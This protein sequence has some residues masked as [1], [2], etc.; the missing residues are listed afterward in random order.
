[1]LIVARYIKTLSSPNTRINSQFHIGGNV[2]L[3]EII[4]RFAL[5]KALTGET[6]IIHSL[7]LEMVVMVE[8]L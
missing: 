2:L 6:M 3:V 5:G 4:K 1:M 8:L 7:L